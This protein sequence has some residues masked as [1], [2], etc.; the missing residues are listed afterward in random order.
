M[1]APGFDPRA[2]QAQPRQSPARAQ[3]RLAGWVAASALL[4][5]CAPMPTQPARPADV[6]IPAT[7][8][9][10]TATT[11]LPADALTDWWD[12]FADPQLTGLVRSALRANTG[13]RGAQAALQQA[14]AL[15]DVTAAA[16][17]P[18]LGSSASAQHSTVGGHSA[19]SNFQ[20]GLAAN[21][22]P[23]V[24]GANRDA[25][26][27]AD[28]NVLAS[29][30]SL[31]DLRVQIAAEVALDYILLRTAQA[32]LQIAT[33]NLASQQETLQI[34]DWRRQAGLVTVLE[35]EQ[36]RAAV[37]QTRAALPVLQT[38]AAQMAHALAVLSAL[39]PAALD[40]RLASL[41]PV[42][43]TRAELAL[44]IPAETL[45]QRADVRSAEHQVA[46][47]LARVGQADA[48]RYPSFAIGGSLGLNA[49]TLGALS[50][51][52]SVV[53]ALL[54]SVNLPIFDAG[55]AR[56]QVRAQQAALEQASQVYAG[57]ILVALKDVEDALVAL[58]DDTAR[59]AFLRNAADAASTAAQL[60]R[61]RY[62]SGIVDFQTVLETQRTEY[63]TQDSLAG[64]A[65]DVSSDQVRL[66]RALGGGWTDAPEPGAQPDRPL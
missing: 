19:G 51:G 43:E 50:N 35:T 48:Q 63:A 44:A 1:S 57:T 64:A 10:A 56:S 4:Y 53:G 2:E 39:P 23:D 52:A 37:E 25:R 55:A 46:A 27:A 6:A 21:W 60:A 22:V 62:S 41:V 17:W 66:F 7:W 36:A 24:F 13:V 65:A 26:D 31:G 11:G 49:L 3:H 33:A 14:R 30:A 8:S 20:V 40:E 38:S 42:P 47:A 29:A 54:A 58:R 59:R 5:A 9:T 18:T 15:R 45:R 34:T 61:Q 28:A 16:L 32:R 12:R